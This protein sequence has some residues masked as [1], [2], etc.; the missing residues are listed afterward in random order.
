VWVLAQRSTTDSIFC[1][2]QVL[3][4]VG[5]GECGVQWETTL[6]IYIII[7]FYL[8]I[9]AVSSSYFPE[10]KLHT[11]HHVLYIVHQHLLSLLKIS[12]HCLLC[13]GL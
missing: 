6:A 3:V 9:A 2:C 1:I 4:G 10:F 13:R 5:V 8:F 7:S 11:L 12:P